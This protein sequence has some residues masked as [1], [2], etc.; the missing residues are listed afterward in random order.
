M[1]E[2]ITVHIT[3]QSGDK[4]RDLWIWSKSLVL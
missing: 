2:Q 1:Q 3:Q 4:L